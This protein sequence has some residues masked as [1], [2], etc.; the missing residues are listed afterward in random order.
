MKT[1][2]GMLLGIVFAVIISISACGGGGGGS[3]SDLSCAPADPS[4]PTYDLT[5]GWTLTVYLD[6]NCYTQVT[7]LVCQLTFTQSG[8][9]ISISGTCE[10]NYGHP[11]AIENLQAILSGSTFYWGGTVTY[12]ETGYSESSTIACT[13]VGF[14]S[15]TQSGE[16]SGTVTTTWRTDNDSGTCYATITG[17]NFSKN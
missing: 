13:S 9:N 3:S 7:S 17:G 15:A 4:D 14:T 11:I 10:D 5:G 1:K 6:G 2:L 12:S 16:I 8:N